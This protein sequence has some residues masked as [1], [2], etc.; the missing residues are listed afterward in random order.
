VENQS[1]RLANEQRE[2][3]EEDLVTLLSEDLQ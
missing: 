2:L 1:N 3:T